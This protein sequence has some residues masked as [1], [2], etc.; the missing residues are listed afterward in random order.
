[1]K[2]N[3]SPPAAYCL[4]L[5]TLAC[6]CL[7]CY[8]KYSPTWE[9]LDARPL[10]DWYDESKIGLFIHWG[11]YS[12]PSYG[13]A[14]DMSAEWY[15]WYLD[16]QHDTCYGSFHNHTYGPNFQYQD[17]APR[18]KAELWDPQKWAELFAKA[19]IRYVVLTTKHHEG[20]TN[21]RSPQVHVRR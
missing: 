20:W 3:A 2:P 5:A 4:I 16:G 15:W 12:V 6:L 13:C 10:P 9:S 17:F 18:F 1:M 11:V 7:V 8:A 21:W 19:G 14:S